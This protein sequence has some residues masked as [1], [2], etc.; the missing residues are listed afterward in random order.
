M[1]A[2][3][4][5]RR[6]MSLQERRVGAVLPTDAWCFCHRLAT[7]LPDQRGGKYK[8]GLSPAM[9]KVIQRLFVEYG[10]EDR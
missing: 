4:D 9:D 7:V 5:I 6:R 2:L 10:I 8:P 3:T 1:L